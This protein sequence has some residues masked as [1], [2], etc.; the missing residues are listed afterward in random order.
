MNTPRTGH[1]AVLLANGKV[2][3]AGGDDPNEQGLASAEIYDPATNK[4]TSTGSM[5][6]PRVARGAVVLKDG[7]VLVTGGGE[8]RNLAE[9]YDPPSGAWHPTGNMTTAREKHAR[10]IITG[11]TRPYHRRITR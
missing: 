4:W 11:W 7:R 3:V 5:L 1:A 8:G 2:L 6:T 10:Y 9:I